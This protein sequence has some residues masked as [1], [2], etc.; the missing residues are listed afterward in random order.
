MNKAV[1]LDRD[2]TVVE[3]VHYL[4]N[5]DDVRLVSKC[6]EALKRARNAGYLLIVIS[7]QSIVGRGTGTSAE[8]NACNA[9]MRDLL[10]DE[11]VE[12]DLVLFCPHTPVDA[13]AENRG[14]V[15]L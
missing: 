11:G 6:A 7:N 12:L 14:R 10:R 15:C 4:K 9:R 2:G 13:D 5:A 8:V 1:F 3:H